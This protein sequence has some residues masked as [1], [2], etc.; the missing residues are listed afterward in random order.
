[1][2][3]PSGSLVLIL[4]GQ[5]YEALTAISGLKSLQLDYFVFLGIMAL[6]ICVGMLLFSR[7]INYVLKRFYNGA[8]AFMIGVTAG[9]LY[10]LWPFK[11]IV[12]M[13][14]YVK[15]AGEI[16]MVENAPVQTNINVFPTDIGAI[17]PALLFFGIG[18]SIMAAL[19]WFGM[20]GRNQ[21]HSVKVKNT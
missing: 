19:Y 13:D 8:V 12:F 17:L 7:V 15:H 5:Y 21:D 3:G 16:L 20:R 6:G 14:K 1:M 18:V 9:S 2:P 11:K 4:L 10:A